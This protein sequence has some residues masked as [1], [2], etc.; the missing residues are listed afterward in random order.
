MRGNYFL[1]IITIW[2]SGFIS[3]QS[4]F[5]PLSSN[6]IGDMTLPDH[7]LFS[8]L[9]NCRVSNFDSTI[10][11]FYNPST[12]SSLSLGM[13]LYSIGLN[14]RYTQMKDVYGQNW[15]L[16][17][18][19]DN[20][21]MGFGLKNHLGFAFG[22]KPFSRVGYEVTQRVKVGADSLKYIYSGKG[23]SHEIFLGI[24]ADLIHLKS[25]K[26]SLGGNLGYIFGTIHQERQSL[27]IGGNSLV[28]HSDGNELKMKTLHYELGISLT[29]KLTNN[30]SLLLTAVLEPQQQ[31]RGKSS[32]YVFYDNVSDTFPPGILK[33]PTDLERSLRLSTKTQFGLAYKLLFKDNRKVNSSRNSEL[34]FH[35]N[36]TYSPLI[37]DT[38]NGETINQ[39]NGWNF[40]IQYTPEIGFNSSATQIKFFEKLHFRA[41]GYVLSTPYKVN[42]V[43]LQDKGITLGLGMP[44]TSFR[45]LS[46][47]N[48][49]LFGGE[50]SSL[51]N[52]DY[53]ERY[54]GLSLGITLAPSNFD[55]WF[56]KRKLD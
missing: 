17:I 46:S 29:Q 13:P 12:Y 11:N 31:L 49:A 40:G 1:F 18:I 25:T 26:L 15:N 53:R 9:G 32:N 45:T 51:S 14:S 4:T 24:S 22:L 37:S 23:G 6:G 54:L 47:I 36:Y 56:V 30:Q 41:G 5:S 27:L 34:A 52:S 16:N 10:L 44:V 39:P 21:A 43:T 55:K 8:G 20:F 7:G 19:P 33:I 3:A 38:L 2:I 50:R 48:F 35:M 28:I 42:G